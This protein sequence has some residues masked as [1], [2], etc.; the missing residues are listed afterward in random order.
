MKTWIGIMLVG[1]LFLGGCRGGHLSGNERTES[2]EMTG[3]IYLGG[4]ETYS[5]IGLQLPSGRA[6][7]LLGVDSLRNYQNRTV[8]VRGYFTR[9]ESDSFIVKQVKILQNP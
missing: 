5:F 6:I 1:L 2:R 7:V 4:T 3:R 8:R 9:A